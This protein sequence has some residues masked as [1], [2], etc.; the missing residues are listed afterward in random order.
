MKTAKVNIVPTGTVKL[1][2]PGPW[3]C[4]PVSDKITNNNRTFEIM[5]FE[6]TSSVRDVL[7]VEIEH[8]ARLIE[9]APELLECCQAM[10]GYLYVKGEKD[11]IIAKVLQD[12]INKSIGC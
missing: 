3:K 12:T 10:L 8:N 9:S 7:P 2:T 4:Y 1:H 5:G 6:T 11:S